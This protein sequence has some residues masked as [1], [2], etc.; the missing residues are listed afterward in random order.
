MPCRKEKFE[1][2]DIVH[3]ILHGVSNDLLFLDLDDYYRG[4]FSIYEFNDLNPA[5]IRRRRELR[6]SFKKKIRLGRTSADFLDNRERMVDILCFSFMPN[7]IHLL[8]RQIKDSGITEFMRKL[9]TG[10][11]G[12]IIRK[13]ERKGH[14]FQRSFEAV[15]VETDEQLMTV[16]AYIHT[17]AISLIYKDWKKIR[18]EKYEFNKII[19]FLE[20]YRWHSYL[21]YIGIKNFPSVTHRDFMLDL[22][23]GEV[24]CKEFVENYIRNKGEFSSRSDLGGLAIYF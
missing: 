8:L 4:I 7:H 3:I 13:Y 18:I 2:G 24:K 14:V 12:Y 21:D 9:G 6:N 23:G 17:N 10:Y 5:N 15:K 16:F 11:A 1:N 19:K 20:N 22:F